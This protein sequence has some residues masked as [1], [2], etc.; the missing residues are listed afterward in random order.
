MVVAETGFD[1]TFSI[2]PMVRASGYSLI[3]YTRIFVLV[4]SLRA[5]HI[6]CPLNCCFRNSIHYFHIKITK[7]FK[8]SV[9]PLN[10]SSTYLFET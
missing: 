3:K 2:S 10:S 1:K 4:G 9:K 6:L 5:S 8:A 7:S